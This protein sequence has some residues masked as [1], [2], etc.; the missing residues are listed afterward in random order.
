MIQIVSFVVC[1]TPTLFN[2]LALHHR[3]VF[4]CHEA[5]KCFAIDLGFVS[6]LFLYVCL[7]VSIRTYRPYLLCSYQ[8][9]RELYKRQNRA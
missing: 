6:T 4:L 1:C 7:D 3:I 5:K 9:L 2:Y 8:F